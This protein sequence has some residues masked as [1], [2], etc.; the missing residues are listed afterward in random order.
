MS[1]MNWLVI[2][3]LFLVI[4]AVTVNL[5]TVWFAGGA[6]AAALASYFH[7]SVISQLVLFVGVSIILLMI[8]R[9]LAAKF[10]KSSRTKTNVDSL[11]GKSAI[12]TEEINN[13][14]QTGKVKINDVDW[15]AR[16]AS[17]EDSIPEGTVVEI[18]EVRGVKLIV[19]PS[20]IT[21]EKGE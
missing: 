13:L 2:M 12:V 5:V 21:L 9:P 6:L 3:I 11:L 4:E 10:M 8:T 19:A 1:F 18:K 20:K 14:E 17:D 16:T 15:L 7:A